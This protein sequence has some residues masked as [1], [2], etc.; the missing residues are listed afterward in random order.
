MKLYI[1]GRF[2]TQRITGV[3]RYAIEIVKC[4]DDILN[5]EDDVTILIPPEP[6]VNTLDLKNIKQ[7]RIGKLRGHFW[8][9]VS[10]P[11]Y[12]KKHDGE[13]LTF[14][15]IAP[16]LSPGY[17]TVHDITF[18][19]HPE[20][21][22]WKFRL[23]YTIALKLGL[24]RSK[25]VFTVSEFS[26][27]EIASH[28]NMPKEKILVAYSSANYLLNRPYNK[29]DILKYGL[30]PK[31]YY[32]SVSSKN[33]HKNQSFI[34][35][36]AQEHPDITFVIAGGEHK[37]FNT[38]RQHSN[39]VENTNLIYT[40]YVNDDD[41]ASLY[42]AAKGFIFPSVYE[43]FGLP[44]LEAIILGCKSIALS[45]IPVFREIY[46]N[47]YF[48]NPHTPKDFSFTFFDKVKITEDERINYIK[49]YS[50]ATDAAIYRDTIK[51]G[52][53]KI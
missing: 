49:K 6:L 20:S 39:V 30:K 51:S 29:V 3:Q 27:N 33:L 46:R 50:F 26:K 15:G 19:R 22:N 41:L 18:I 34:V 7:K 14:S 53:M 17:W 13:L 42:K 9:Q 52:N 1:N 10:L 32:L 12:I 4:L 16:I 44:P 37:A 48:F 11:L 47:A 2:L 24:K 25:K 38:N 45:D 28:F 43:G 8:I 23:I 40:G 35:E 5:D 31:S 21:F 36:L